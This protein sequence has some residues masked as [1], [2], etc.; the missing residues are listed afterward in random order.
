M[1][2]QLKDALLDRFEAFELCEFLQVP[3]EDFYDAC[4]E[5]G[6]IN[7]D[8]VEDVA[9]LVGLRNDEENE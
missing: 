5:Y 3:I 1:N 7:E 4:M 6:W 9:D 2:K 8:N